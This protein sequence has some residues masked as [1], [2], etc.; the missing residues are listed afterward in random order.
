MAVP[1]Q[2]TF[3]DFLFPLKRHQNFEMGENAPYLASMEWSVIL[4]MCI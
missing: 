4:R 1:N 3:N 2:L